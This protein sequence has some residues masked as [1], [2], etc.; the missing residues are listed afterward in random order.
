MTTTDDPGLRRRAVLTVLGF[1][2]VGVLVPVVGWLV[3]VWLVVRT[4]AWSATEKAV[5]LLAPPAVLLAGFVV[6]ALAADAPVAPVVLALPITLSLASGIG[7]I[8]LANRLVAHKR[9]GE[10]G[11]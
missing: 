6:L 9:A 5:G 1:A 3:G 8:H 2:L 10:V 11:R 4:P 7:A